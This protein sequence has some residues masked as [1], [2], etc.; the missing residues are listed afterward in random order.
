MK[1]VAKWGLGIIFGLLLVVTLIGLHTWHFKPAKIDWFYTRVFAAFAI[2]SPEMLSSMRILPGWLDF[3]SDKLDDNSLEAQQ[4]QFDQLKH[5]LATLTSYK[6]DA[7]SGEER[8]SYDIMRHFLQAMADGERFRDHA[9]PIN[10]NQGLQSGLPEFMVN[11]HQVN[12]AADANN[13]I[14][15]LNKFPL[16]FDQ[17]L[18]QVKLS[19]SKGI[20]PPRFTIDKVLLEMK[21]YVA[22][23]AAQSALYVSFADKL[24]KIPAAEMDAATRT[25]LQ[26]EVLKSINGS[27]Y[28]AYRSMIG[29]FTGLQAKTQAN[30]GAWSLPDGE[31][32]Y[33]WT[34]RMHTTTEMTAQQVHDIGLAEVARVGAEMDALLKGQGLA[35]GS[36]GARYQTLAKNP[37]QQYPNTPEGKKEMVARYQQIM[38]DINK[39]MDVAFSV[40]PKLGVEVKPIPEASQDSA[41][42]AYY[43]PGSMD[44]SRPGMF[45]ANIRNP[46]ETPKFGMSTLAYHEGI[47]GHHFQIAIQQELEG[48]P[49]F[50][51]VVPFTAYSEGWA[52][53]SEKLASELG[54]GTDPLDTLGRLS[55]EMM[56]AT[57]LVIDTGIHSKRWTREQAIEYMLDHTGMSETD[58]VAEVE[59][60]FV[61]PGQALAYKV[62]MLKILALR[63]NA[64][65]QLGPKFDLKQ[66]HNEVLTHGAMP[67]TVLEGVVNDWIGRRKAAAPG[68]KPPATDAAGRAQAAR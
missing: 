53:Y 56:R 7:L 64:Q 51:K 41:P 15:R 3:Y 18:S 60:Y 33:A 61:N 49:F 11:V 35:E 16:K 6:R 31:A 20:T 13:Y 10:Q 38:D 50:R 59:R 43:M 65:D 27:V 36:I 23:P 1:C 8:L 46:G 67:M 17:V 45:F 14:A 29:Y 24:A 22:K 55:A 25:Q 9:F 68:E 26:A 63:E 30:S 52:L 42:G 34:V 2:K 57:R 12:S 4:E 48:V 21:D 54:Y 62:G 32:Y 19:E 66:F 58:V 39:G 37:E 5:D 28:P 40:R 44:G 47:P